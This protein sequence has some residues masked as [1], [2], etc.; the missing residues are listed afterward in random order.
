LTGTDD[1]L[2][3]DP[4]RTITTHLEAGKSNRDQL[5]TA[6]GTDHLVILPRDWESATAGKCCG[7]SSGLWVKRFGIQYANAV[8]KRNKWGIPRL[9]SLTLTVFLIEHVNMERCFLA[10]IPN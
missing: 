2:F 8:M 3:L 7:T 6:V 5:K 9:I 1:I 10:G 4:D